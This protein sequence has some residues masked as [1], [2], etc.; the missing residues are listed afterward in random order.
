MR[1]EAYFYPPQ[2]KNGYNNPYALHFKEALAAKYDVAESDYRPVK[3]QLWSL[4]CHALCSDVFFLNWIEN[5]G[6]GRKQKLRTWI[7]LFCLKIMSWRHAPMVWI[8]HN[9][10]PHE[11]ENE[12]TEAIKNWLFQ[13]ANLIIAHSHA[14]ENYAREHARN[15][16]LFLHHPITPIELMMD[17]DFKLD[18]ANDVFIWGSI[19][20]YKG[21]G[22]FVSLP[23]LHDSGLRVKIVGQCQNPELAK[24][25]ESYCG[26]RIT[27]NNHMAIF[28]E[29][30]FHI[31]ASRY[32]LFPYI[33]SG[34]SSSGAL[35]D[36]LMLGGTPLAPDM[37]AFKDLKEEG[38]CITYN[39]EDELFDILN[40]GTTQRIDQDKVKTFIENNSWE[41]FIEKIHDNLK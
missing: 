27:F 26:E 5:V 31:K 21:I 24:Q 9:I 8:L 14:A 41:S 15:K 33:D 2:P 13:H 25:I 10:H 30:A 39:S 3:G 17:D 16:V 11:G 28:E 23:R 12:S 22:E 20:P 35:I 36:T 4:F 1:Q 32:V 40:S 34:F 29:I 6:V 38:L 18:C 7:A 37:G 19:L